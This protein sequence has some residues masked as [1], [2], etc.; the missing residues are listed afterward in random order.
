MKRVKGPRLSSTELKR[1]KVRIT[2]YL[3]K[4]ILEV[5]RK[6]AL[7]SGGKYQAILNQLLRSSL[8]GEKAGLIS[9]IERLER[10]VLKKKAA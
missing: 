10:I 9:R 7:Q 4:D 8:L 2:T 1:A 5:L 6:L 3:D